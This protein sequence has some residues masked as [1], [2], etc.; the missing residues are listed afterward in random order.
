[1]SLLQFNWGKKKNNCRDCE[2]LPF[3]FALIAHMHVDVLFDPLLKAANLEPGINLMLR[4]GQR[5]VE[6]KRGSWHH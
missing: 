4:A 3:A 1:M 2:W 5:M 6:K